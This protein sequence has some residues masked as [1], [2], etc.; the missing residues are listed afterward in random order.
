MADH[1]ET[2]PSVCACSPGWWDTYCDQECP[3]DCQNGGTCDLASDE[4]G[5]Q[6]QVTD[7]ICRCPDDFDGSLCQFRAGESIDLPPPG[8]LGAGNDPPTAVVAIAVVVGVLVIVAAFCV[9]CFLKKRGKD[10]RKDIRN[11]SLH[12]DKN[13]GQLTFQEGDSNDVASGGV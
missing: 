7:F 12:Q 9:I 11:A 13:T 3:I 10:N 8:T 6:P 5:G 1:I 2:I 4:H